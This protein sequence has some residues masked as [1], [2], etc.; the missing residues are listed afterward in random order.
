M[1]YISLLLLLISFSL[2]ANEKDSKNFLEGVPKEVQLADCDEL[3][4]NDA[5]L[6]RYPELPKVISNCL[7]PPPRDTIT[8][9]SQK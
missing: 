1:K 7:A 5:D 8:I 3:P 2:W 9:A 4:V 6:S